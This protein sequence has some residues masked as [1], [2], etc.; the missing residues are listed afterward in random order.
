MKLWRLFLQ[1]H[2]EPCPSRND[3][4]YSFSSKTEISTELDLYKDLQQNPTEDV[5]WGLEMKCEK[6]PNFLMWLHIAQSDS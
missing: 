2:L 5:L 1:F 6:L 4:I 3:G